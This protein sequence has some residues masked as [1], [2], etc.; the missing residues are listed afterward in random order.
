MTIYTTLVINTAVTV[1]QVQ[2]LSS[3]FAGVIGPVYVG[4]YDY[5]RRLIAQSGDVASLIAPSPEPILTILPLLSPT[6]LPPGKYY[7]AF[8]I[9][10]GGGQGFNLMSTVN[11]MFLLQ[12]EPYS[13]Y[14]FEAGPLPDY[15]PFVENGYYGVAPFIALA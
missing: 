10:L 11:F 3:A 13:N 5:E 1:S 8:S 4:I 12:S 6:A 15:L 14:F 7:V 9:E 2:V